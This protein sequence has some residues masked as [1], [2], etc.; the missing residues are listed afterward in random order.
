[1]AASKRK[2][3]YVSLV[4]KEL[5]KYEGNFECSRL[6]FAEWERSTSRDDQLVELDKYLEEDTDLLMIGM[7][8]SDKIKDEIKK[9]VAEEFQIPF[10]ELATKY[11]NEYFYSQ[12]GS[13]VEGDIGEEKHK[14][15]NVFVAKHP[16][17]TGMRAIANEILECLGYY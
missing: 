14:I 15:D 16:G 9:K 5:S 10:I 6:N 7:F 13:N 3:D 17:D 2:K 11:D 8:W 4:A 12:I 1:M